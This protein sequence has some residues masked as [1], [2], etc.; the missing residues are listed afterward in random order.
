MGCVIRGVKV[1]PS[2]Q[3]LS[4]RL[5]AVGGR[6]INN[7]VDATNY[8]LHGFG[9]PMHAFDLSR[10]DGGK[11]IVRRAHAGEKIRTLDGVDRTLDEEMTVIADGSRA[12]A[13]AGVI[14]GEGSEVSIRQPIFFSR[15]PRS[16]H[17]AFGPRVESLA[18]R[19]TRATASSGALMLIP[20]LLSWNTRLCSLSRSPV[21]CLQS[22]RTFLWIF[23]NPS[24]SE[25]AASA[26]SG[27]L[28][29]RS[30]QTK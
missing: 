1:K 30:M 18:S 23:L 15:S 6:S 26:S 9:Q 10:L 25:F 28:A 7:V 4:S 17:N 16:I 22:L 2:P 14:G 19:L 11:I 13:I 24:Q 5:E 21:A 20:F 12:Q 3:W 8:M 27:F 29:R